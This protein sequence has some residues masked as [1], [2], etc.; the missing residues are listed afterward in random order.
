MG[1]ESYSRDNRVD[2]VRRVHIDGGVRDLDVGLGFPLGVGA[3]K[4]GLFDH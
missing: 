3:Q 2:S 1:E 4:V